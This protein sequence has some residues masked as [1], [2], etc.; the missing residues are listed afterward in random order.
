M[1]RNLETRCIHSISAW[2]MGFYGNKYHLMPKVIYGDVHIDSMSTKKEQETTT[3][4]Q[5]QREQQEAVNKALD[6]TKF[7]IKKATNEAKKEIPRYTEA[8]SEYQEQ[9]IEAARDIAETYIESQKEIINAF[10]SAYGPYVE[11]FYSRTWSPVISS[12]RISEVYA[13][14]VSNHADNFVTATRLTNN[15][16]FAGMEAFKTSLQQTKEIVKDLSRLSVNT[17]KTFE[18]TSRESSRLST[19]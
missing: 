14:V 17:A 13:N 9:T 12:R 16:V 1:D 4:S 3:T 2:I 15:M 10:Q 19:V 5:L 18:Q 8:V 11:T 7:D 6:E